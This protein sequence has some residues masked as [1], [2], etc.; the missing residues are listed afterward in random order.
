MMNGEGTPS[1]PNWQALAE[2]G[3]MTYSSILNSTS[4]SPASQVTLVKTFSA[5]KYFGRR[6]ILTEDDFRGT[7]TTNPAE[8]AYFHLFVAPQDGVS[9]TASVRCMVEIEYISVYTELRQLAQS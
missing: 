7:S 8:M 5:R 6:G 1:V 2:Q 9:N 4:N 3:N